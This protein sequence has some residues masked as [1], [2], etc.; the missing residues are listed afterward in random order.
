MSSASK[1]KK[2]TA[3]G[4]K[5]NKIFISWSGE[6]TKNFAINLKNVLEET[7]FSKSDADVECF[8]SYDDIKSGE[9]WWKKIGKEL[10]TCSVGI[11]C[12]SNENL[13]A[14]WIYYEAGSLASRGILAIPLLIG[15]RIDFLHE[16]LSRRQAI[17][18]EKQ[19]K[20][21][22][23]IKDINEHFGLPLKSSDVEERA[24]EGHDILNGKLASTISILENLKPVSQYYSEKN[25]D[26]GTIIRNAQNDIFVSTAVGNKFLA[27]YA[28]DIEEKLK[29]G[30]GVQYMLLGL[31]RFYEME[32]YLHGK[33]VKSEKIHYAVLKILKSWKEKYPDLLIAKYF[34]GYMTASYVGV[35]IEVELENRKIHDSSVLQVMHYQ[36]RTKAKN[37]PIQYIFPEKDDKL[38]YS[39]VES[40]VAMWRSG[41]KILFT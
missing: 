16:S 19:E 36:F 30:V 2:R 23:M 37:S 20:F 10:K 8:V 32:E 35:D 31:D 41:E 13:Y 5:K 22:K 15:C 12:V 38:F 40:V 39:T 27:K 33:D 9:E 21:I 28:D 24:I 25:H 34:H 26:V 7:V 11:V 6:F 18:F 14:P 1:H 29:A 4:K 3:K 17:E